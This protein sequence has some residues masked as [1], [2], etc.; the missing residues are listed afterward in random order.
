MSVYVDD[1]KAPYR[2]MKMCHMTADTAEEL[3]AMANRLGLPY[4]MHQSKS[5]PHYDLSQSVRKLAI[6]CGAISETAME[7]ARRR[8]G[9]VL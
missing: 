6:A 5:H 9:S 3:Q 1:C 4:W 8:M 2:N 7:G